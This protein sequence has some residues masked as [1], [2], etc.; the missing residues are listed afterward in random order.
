MAVNGTGLSPGVVA[1][2]RRR[3]RR[4]WLVVLIATGLVAA[5]AVPLGVWFAVATVQAGEGGKTPSV[6]VQGVL[7]A[8]D[9]EAGRTLPEG[10][11][12]A[13]AG[14][15]AWVLRHPPG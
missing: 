7:S 9:R 5:C 6:A 15:G 12:R 8:L 2:P 14:A 10:R 1:G 4:W 3:S 13:P 11:Q